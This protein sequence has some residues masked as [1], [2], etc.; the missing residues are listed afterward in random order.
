MAPPSAASDFGEMVSRRCRRCSAWVAAA[1]TGCLLAVAAASSSSAA[2][3]EEATAGEAIVLP[4]MLSG[5]WTPI[6]RSVGAT[7]RTVLPQHTNNRY[8]TSRPR[9]RYSHT[10]TAVG[11]EVVVALGYYYDHWDGGGPTWLP[12]VWALSVAAAEPRW[13]LVTD[14]SG[15]APPPR[16]NHAAVALPGGKA[17]LIYS[18]TNLRHE[19]LQDVWE[20][21]VGSGVWA[22]HRQSGDQ[23]PGRNCFAAALLGATM[24]V[25]GGFHLG[26]LWSYELAAR[27]WRLLLAA[28]AADSEEH[29]GKRAG[30]AA[31]A[32]PGGK[33]FFVHG[34]FR[35]K[36]DVSDAERFPW[37][38]LGDLWAYSLEQGR[39]RQLPQARPA[40]GRANFALNLVSWPTTEAS[41]ADGLGAADEKELG[42]GLLAVGGTRCNATQ[43]P[44][45]CS[46]VADMSFYSLS[47]GRW[48][49]VNVRNPRL[50]RYYHSCVLHAGAL[51]LFGGESFQPHMYH[52]GVD[53]FAWPPPL[54]ALPAE[55]DVADSALPSEV[56]EL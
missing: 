16:M 10:A 14:G 18:G 40:N 54:E 8:G 9:T 23:P 20:L 46:L 1:A 37:G 5:N 3:A 27:R 17:L 30:H 25:Y 43:Y 2:G 22:E 42:L 21:D 41:T 15:V 51:W 12:D 4:H 53:A 56:A 44:Q 52:N 35:F 33:E 55:R 26:D 13:R 47:A 6:T 38:R 50:H 36:D 48:L 39:W 28:P 29:P 31:V 24:L 32:G 7:W 11:S 49:E 45:S 34:G 19:V